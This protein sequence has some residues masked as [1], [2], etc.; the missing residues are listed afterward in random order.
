MAGFSLCGNLPQ[1]TFEFLKH[2]DCP[3]T[4][5]HSTEV[6]FTAQQLAERFDIDCQQAEAAAWLHDISAVFPNWQRAAVSSQLGI[7]ILPEEELVPL[8]LHQKISAVMAAEMF[9]VTDSKVLAAIR[10][11]TTLRA[12]PSDLD[13]L[14]FAADKL[15]WDQRG[16]PPYQHEMEAALD[17][18]LEAAVWVYQRYLWYSGKIKMIHPWM[19][20][21]YEELKV[22]YEML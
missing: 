10:C 12:D 18:S 13:L 1:D 3:I 11:H 17:N 14:V 21:S 16:T 7:E 5:A 6:A 2:H 15:A 20:D 22:R 8:L 4:A 9:G 19:R